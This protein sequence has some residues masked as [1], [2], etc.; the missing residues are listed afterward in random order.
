MRA[1]VEMLSHG[2]SGVARYR[3]A[4]GRRE[5]VVPQLA[6]AVARR[7]FPPGR[8]EVHERWVNVRKVRPPWRVAADWLE[9]VQG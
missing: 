2:A 8:I 4:A 1:E 6:R 7:K 5:E 9:R 3:E